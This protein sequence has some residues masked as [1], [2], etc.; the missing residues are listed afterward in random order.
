MNSVL[1]GALRQVL[2]AKVNVPATKISLR[3]GD[4]N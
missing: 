4:Q 2:S 1:R 3:G